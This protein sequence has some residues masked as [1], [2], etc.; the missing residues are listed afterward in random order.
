MDKIVLLENETMALYCYPNDGIVHHVIYKFCFGET[1]RTLLTKGAD[2]FIQYKC[3]KWLSD[4][5]SNSVLR[6]E[7]V[8]WG[9]KNWEGRIIN[10]W[11]YWALIVPDKVVGKMSMKPLID[12]YASLGVEVK[13]FE[14][15]DEALKW[16]KSLK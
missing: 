2:A 15:S 16:L 14:N 5:K 8:E 1:F 3:T 9:Q 11:K 12:R 10:N 6:Q 7:D 4:D 13:L